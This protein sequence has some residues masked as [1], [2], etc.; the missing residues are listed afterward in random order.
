MEKSNEL[1][2]NY[3]CIYKIHYIGFKIADWDG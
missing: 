2:K 1:I 3:L